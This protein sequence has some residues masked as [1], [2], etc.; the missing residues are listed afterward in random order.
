[1][2][3]A[4]LSDVPKEPW[5]S[6][7]GKFKSWSQAMNDAIGGDSASTDLTKRWP[8]D[9][10]RSSIAPGAAA[11]PYHS[12]TT[13][14]EFYVIVSGTGVVRHREGETEIGAGDFFMFCP[15][16]PHQ[17]V[18]RGSE[19]LLYYCIADN[20]IADT[21]YYPDSKKWSVRVPERQ[22]IT[23]ARRADYLEGEDPKPPGDDSVDSRPPGI[24]L[25]PFLK[26]NIKAI[27]EFRT[28]SPKGKYC[29]VDRPLNE[30]IGGD[31]WSMDL[32][33]R[34]PFEVE[35]TLIPAGKINYSFHCHSSQHEFYLI[36]SGHATVRHKEG[37]TE[38]GP[39]DFF[40]FGPNEPHQM[41]NH[42]TEDVIYYCVADN[43]IGDHAYLVDSNK[44]LVRLPEPSLFI[45]G[46]R[47]DRFDGEE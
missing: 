34:W 31:S 26:A 20:P 17:L 47:A 7:T 21:C 30:T 46:A 8:F 6:P 22:V 13:Q 24:P 40:I 42:G 16:E 41:L 18:N 32:A 39:G 37:T 23:G 33:K 4:N 3:K 2:R 28:D 5:R 14:Y 38:A 11:W 10:E 44:Y 45:Q 9:V 27:P 15:R 43:P 35:W 19:E 25:R 12:H 36:V 1:M 29:T